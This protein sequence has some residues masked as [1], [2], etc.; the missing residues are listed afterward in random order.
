MFWNIA[1]LQVVGS[2]SARTWSAPDP[3]TAL[4]TSGCWLRRS[5]LT[6]RGSLGRLGG[7]RQLGCRQFFFSGNRIDTHVA[8]QDGARLHTSNASMAFL[9][10]VFGA[11][12]LSDRSLKSLCNL[13]C[14]SSQNQVSPRTELGAQLPRSDPLRLLPPRLSQGD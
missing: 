14:Y 7:T 1:I 10:Q 9:D 12:L 6:Y 8:M 2:S 4:N 3:T 13:V 5:F 11:R